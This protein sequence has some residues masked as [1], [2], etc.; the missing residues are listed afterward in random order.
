MVEHDLDLEGNYIK[1][2]MG[3]MSISTGRV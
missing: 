2:E 3:D 1:A